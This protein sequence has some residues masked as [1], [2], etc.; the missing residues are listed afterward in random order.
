M[1][2]QLNRN[3]VLISIRP[4][5]WPRSPLPSRPSDSASRTHSR[6]R[7]SRNDNE[8]SRFAKRSSPHQRVVPPHRLWKSQ[9][10][11]KNAVNRARREQILAA[12]HQSHTLQ[13]II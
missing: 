8:R 3:T 6:R 13:S 2:A 9:Q 5:G 7:S 10:N 11:L 12:R 4:A 1:T